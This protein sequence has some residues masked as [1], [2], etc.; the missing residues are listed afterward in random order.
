[1]PDNER[2][3]MRTVDR[4][5][6]LFRWC[7]GLAVAGTVV[8]SAGCGDDPPPPQ[9]PP[10]PVVEKRQVGFI[11]KRKVV[12]KPAGIDLSGVDPKTIFE[13]AKT[14]L[15]NYFALGP[16]PPEPEQRFTAMPPV[17]GKD[18]SSFAA[19]APT[20]D[21]GNR[22]GTESSPGAVRLPSGFAPAAGATWAGGLPSRIL[23]EMDGS[24]LVL[25]EGG[26]SLV[27]SSSG[28]QHWR[29]QVQVGLAPFYISDREITVFQFLK[30]RTKV[31]ARGKKIEEPINVDAPENHPALGV[32]WAEARSYAQ[33]IGGELPSEAQWEK[34]ARG[35]QG[36]RT[37][38]GNSRPL[39]R[40]PRAMD[41]ID[42]IGSHPDD[43]S[44]YGAFD[45]AGNA[46]EWT[47]DFF[48]ED[49]FSVLAELPFD[50]RQNWRGPRNP[51]ATALRVVKGNGPD[52]TVCHREGVRMNERSEHIGFRY[53]LNL[54][55][56]PGAQ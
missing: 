20:G 53:V 10:Q 38:W 17:S 48:R 46:R 16:A 28:P 22:S 43:R 33:W 39:W 24:S 2:N 35:P 51:S 30:F 49:S 36:F 44:V 50:R 7:C 27:G 25:V 42:A 4:T 45:M 15:P 29:P 14:P 31:G 9:P 34:T 26:T 41:Q 47:G 3:G 54:T 19:T 55:A 32:T 12:E 40:V 11:P 13:E 1:M 21:T 6:S 5:P 56:S 23:C 37:P 52:W 8:I 18:S